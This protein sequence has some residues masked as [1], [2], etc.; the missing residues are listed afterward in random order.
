[1]T[2]VEQA[3]VLSG[4]SSLSALGGIVVGHWLNRSWQQRQWVLDNRKSE[5]RELLTALAE[6]YTALMRLREGVATSPE[7]QTMI[8]DAADKAI[9]CLADRIFLAERL[10][11]EDALNRWVKAMTTFHRELEPFAL[12]GEYEGLRATIIRTILEGQRSRGRRW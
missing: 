5:A 4:V 8:D 2:S 1:M 9:R 7:V 3:L 6:S 12:R 11:R 10:E